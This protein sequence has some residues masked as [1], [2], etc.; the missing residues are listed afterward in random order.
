MEQQTPEIPDPTTLLIEDLTGRVAGATLE[1]SQWKARAIA[2]EARLASIA[3]AEDED[4]GEAQQDDD[5]E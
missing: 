5:G 3:E 1:A 4:D 2:A